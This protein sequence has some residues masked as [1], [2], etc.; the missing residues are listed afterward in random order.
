MRVNIDSDD[1]LVKKAMEIS[2]QNTQK[3]AI[4]IILSEYIR[5]HNQKYTGYKVH[6]TLPNRSC[7]YFAAFSGSGYVLSQVSNRRLSI[8]LVGRSA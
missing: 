4:N 3:A 1:T 7:I 8:L 6:P 5:K 2:G